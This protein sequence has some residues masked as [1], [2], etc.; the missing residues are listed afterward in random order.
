MARDDHHLTI[1]FSGT[2]HFL[3]L[4]N[5]AIYIQE[6]TS[7]VGHPSSSY[8]QKDIVESPEQ[9]ASHADCIRTSDEQVKGE[10]HGSRA[11]PLLYK[12]EVHSCL[13]RKHNS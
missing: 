9:F 7:Y 11:P 12:G 1:F 2:H 8:S 3:Y 6:I 4:C 5:C 10:T 13:L